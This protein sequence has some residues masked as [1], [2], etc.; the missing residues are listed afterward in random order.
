M[1]PG[2]IFVLVIAATL[3]ACG[4]RVEAPDLPGLA[5]GATAKA[6]TAFRPLL[7]RWSNAL[8]R[9]EQIGRAHV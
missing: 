4:S 8:T 3:A 1:R 6:Q 9:E 2:L 7:K 5:L